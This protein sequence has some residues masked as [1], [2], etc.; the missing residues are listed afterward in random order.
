MPPA[1]LS[2]ALGALIYFYGKEVSGHSFS[3]KDD[4]ANL[5]FFDEIWKDN[6]IDNIVQKTLSNTGLWDQDLT[7]IKPIKDQVSLSLKAI[8]ANLKIS[9]AYEV[10]IKS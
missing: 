4:A 7:K 10:Y 2:F 9:E 3:L 6:S 8:S 1:H 5:S